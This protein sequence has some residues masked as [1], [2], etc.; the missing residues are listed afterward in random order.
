MNT[1][2]DAEFSLLLWSLA[3]GVAGLGW[4]LSNG[5]L[6]MA[7]GGPTL[8]GRWGAFVLAGGALGVG[9]NA[10]LLL[11]LE[12]HPLTF[13]LRFHTLGA[14]AL[15]VAGLVGG[16]LVAAIAFGVAP[17]WRLLLSGAVLAMLALGL[18]AG[19]MVAAGF[20]PGVVWQQD[21]LLTAALVLLVGLGLARW[22]AFCAAV[23]GSPRRVAWRLAAAVLAALSLM[24]GQQWLVLAAGLAAQ[25]GSVNAGP[26]SGALLSLVSGVLVPLVM[27]AMALDLWLRRRQR[28]RRSREGTQP[29]KRRKR[30]RRYRAL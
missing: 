16:A 10:A 20:K 30:R 21:L 2:T 27:A 6:R 5:W 11:G 23:E 7:E 18:Q 12:A 1:P 24:A 25:R 9:L 28:P 22:L 8:R 13:P 26:L 15:L 29:S 17:A 3:V 19:W 4:H 14:L